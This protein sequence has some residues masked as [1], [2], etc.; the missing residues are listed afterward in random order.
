MTKESQFGHNSAD[1]I[2]NPASLFSTRRQCQEV[3]IVLL[4]YRRVRLESLV[5]EIVGIKE[6]SLRGPFT[7]LY[8]IP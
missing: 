4:A 6:H 5:Q 1:I 7:K 2:K 8:V 3:G